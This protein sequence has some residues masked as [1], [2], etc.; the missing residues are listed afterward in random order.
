MSKKVWLASFPRSGN[1]FFRN[2]LFHVYGIES[3]ENETKYIDPT[4]VNT[5]IK[6]HD[7]P[8]L[9]KTY[10]PQDTVIYLVRDGRD[11]ICS[12]ANH[13]KNLIDV[14]SD[15]DKNYEEATKAENGAF[16]GGWDLN[17][18]F[19]LKENPI[20]IRFED[21]IADPIREFSKI[22]AA[23]DLPKPNWENLPTFE[24][25]K[26]AE[27]RFGNFLKKDPTKSESQKFFR[28]GKVG[29][30]KEEL[31]KEL[32]KL[33]WSKSRS[34]ME[35][36]GYSID[37]AVNEIDIDKMAVLKKQAFF[38]DKTKLGYWDAKKRFKKFL[39]RS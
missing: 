23:V 19:W 5:F 36:L 7:L 25:Q 14:H 9:L 24:K 27:S 35:A 33:F 38:W 3:I 17:C 11:S 21:L 32:Q 20:L 6:T 22:E 16:F 4:Q 15:L 18:K 8:F 31:P 30:W 2:I 10:S 12:V 39:K 13:R 29:G 26:N 34:T 28:Q 37:G 1:T